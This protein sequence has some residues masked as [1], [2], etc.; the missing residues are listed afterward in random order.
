MTVK[1]LSAGVWELEGT[2]LGEGCPLPALT[3]LFGTGEA[4]TVGIQ[5]SGCTLGVSMGVTVHTSDNENREWS[6]LWVGI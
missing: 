4:F 5:G 3:P 6:F 1:L 2:G